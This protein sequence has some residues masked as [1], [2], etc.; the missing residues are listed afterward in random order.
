MQSVF[1]VRWL[2]SGSVPCATMTKPLEQHPRN[3]TEHEGPTKPWRAFWTCLKLASTS[4]QNH[5]SGQCYHETVLGTHTKKHI[6]T[7]VRIHEPC[8]MRLC[9]VCTNRP[10]QST[11]FRQARIYGK[12]V[13]CSP[14]LA[15]VDPHSFILRMPKLLDPGIPM[16]AFPSSQASVKLW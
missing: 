8:S 4:L 5:L 12:A 14:F 15:C 3:P 16:Q 10:I 13:S 11:L 2:F 1:C 7:H 6:H 9:V